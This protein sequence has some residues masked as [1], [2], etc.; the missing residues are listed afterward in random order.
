M[1]IEA[2]RLII[3]KIA[4]SDF[5]S[6]KE[7][8]A[9][10]EVGQYIYG[11]NGITD[12]DIRKTFDYNLSLP[13]S[14]SVMLKDSFKIIGNIHL[15]NITD[16]Y[17]AEAGYILD[18]NHWG[19][20]YM[21]EALTSVMDFAFNDYGL[22]KILAITETSNTHSVNLLKRC[23][24]MHETTIYET[25]YNGRLVDLSYYCAKRDVLGK[26]QQELLSSLSSAASLAQIQAYIKQV[27]PMRG[28][29]AQ[30][31]HHSLLLLCEEV[32]EL[33][34]A[35]RKNTV[36]MSYDK[37]SDFDSA[38]SELADILIVICEIAN[39]L[40]IDLHDAFIAKEKV[41]VGRNWDF[42]GNDKL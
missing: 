19:K 42:V 24:F 25:S 33:A 34:K 2:D 20:G 22:A 21:T 17:L 41:N 26:S 18:P 5:E 36:G 35:I 9:H 38:E 27:L 16:N 14:W 10:P 7:Y 29:N 23:G 37:H 31:V 30:S 40:N 13:L 8:Y 15:A 32:G 12:A 1:K 28:I 11:Q 6:F 39:T 4:E 3:Q